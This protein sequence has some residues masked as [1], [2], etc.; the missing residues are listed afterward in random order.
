MIEIDHLSFSYGTRPVLQDVSCQI[1]PRRLTFLI[2]QNGAGKSTLFRCIL[3]QLPTKKGRILLNGHMI[4][5]Y[6]IREMAKYISYVPQSS[7]PVFSYPVRQVVLMGRSAYTSLFSSPGKEDEAI[8]Q[9]AMERLGIAHLAEQRFANL[10]G[11]EQQLVLIARALA[12]QGQVLLMDEPTAS[13]DYGNQLKVLTQIKT[14][15]QDGMSVLIS[16]H[17]PQHALWFADEM[18][19]LDGGQVAAAGD[20]QTVMTPEL[21]RQ[22]YQVEVRLCTNDNVRFMLPTDL[23]IGGEMCL[24]GMTK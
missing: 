12:Q 23:Q 7:N 9:Q 20:T 22:L 16:S 3:G 18:I 10:S 5:Q 17:N 2:G 14:L 1:K 4:S 21:I 13:L 8:A 24:N 19:A 11:G 15:C 6:T